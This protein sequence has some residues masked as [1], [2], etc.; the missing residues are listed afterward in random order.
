MDERARRVG[1][2]EAL[3]RAINEKIED[4]NRS[5]GGLTGSMTVVCECATL[6]CAEQIEVDVAT[7][8]R[9]RADPT[10][11]I[12]LPGHQLPDIESIEEEHEGFFI[13]RKNEGTPEAIAR[14]TDPRS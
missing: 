13:I 9:V 6:E 12:V 8:E 10:L 4:L 2:N 14:A 3:Y 1:E 11:F 5:F 7:Y